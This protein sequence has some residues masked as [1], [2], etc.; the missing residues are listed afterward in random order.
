MHFSKQKFLNS[1]TKLRSCSNTSTFCQFS[2]KTGKAGAFSFLE[3]IK[4]SSSI[5]LLSLQV[6]SALSNTDCSFEMAIIYME[7]SSSVWYL[8]L[9]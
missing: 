4:V 8:M 9:S 2:V 6:N 5:N 3:N 1:A 7:T